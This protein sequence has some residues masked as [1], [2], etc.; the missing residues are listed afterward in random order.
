STPPKRNTASAA[1]RPARVRRRLGPLRPR[2]RR[3]RTGGSRARPRA[4]E[5]SAWRRTSDLALLD[6][7]GHV[8][9]E[10]DAR[11][12]SQRQ[13]EGEGRAVRKSRFDPDA[14]PMCIH[15]RAADG[16]P[17]ADARRGRF[18]IAACEL[19]ED[20]LLTALCD[21][22]PV[23]AHADVEFVVDR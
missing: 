20:G 12:R 15:D 19:L 17:E 8:V 9:A 2:A 16:E 10:V 23:V 11:R 21:P 4:P 7:R 13:A 6:N 14:A 18:R 22:G 3:A 1:A 5:R